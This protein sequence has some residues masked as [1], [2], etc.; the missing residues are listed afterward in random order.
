M[1]KVSLASSLLSVF[2][3]NL[4]VIHGAK[5][6][7]KVTLYNELLTSAPCSKRIPAAST[8]PYSAAP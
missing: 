8:D 2:N 4:Q 7:I 6:M 1:N 5:E 3:V